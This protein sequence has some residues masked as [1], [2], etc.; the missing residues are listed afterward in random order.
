MDVGVGLPTTVPGVTGG[1]IVE[2]ARRAEGLG[3]ASL[4]VIDRLVYDN[5]EPLVTLA[6]A[7]A[8]TSRIRLASTILIAAYRGNTAL[9]A[10]QLATVDQISGGRLTVGVAA[11]GR[12][13]DFTASGV[14]YAGRGRRLDAM[15]ADL[16]RIWS[17]ES[18]PPVGPR[19]VNGGIPIL[20]GGHSPAAMRRAARWGQGWIAGGSSASGYADL[21]EQARQAWSA[22]GRPGRP[23]MVALAHVALGQGAGE[24]AERHL[25]AYYAFSGPKAV[26]AAKSVL[27]D[28]GRLREHV[29]EYEKVGCDELV[30]LPCV[31]GSDQVDLIAEALR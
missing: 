19:P 20:V 22:Q 13:D 28:P 14:P 8:V 31:T 2:T 29:A 21:A 25:R 27:T 24:R 7:A 26:H 6:A 17:G 10:K 5:Y 18:E 16:A 12:E 11:G 1:E 9:L 15:L 3:F 4:A 23:R 30:L